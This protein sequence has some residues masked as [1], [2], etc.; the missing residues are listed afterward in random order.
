VISFIVPGTPRPKGSLTH[1]A[2]GVMLEGK[3]A[4]ARDRMAAYRW[5]VATVARTAM[6]RKKL[7]LM[8]GAL[9]LTVVFELPRPKTVR[10]ARP[11]RKPDLDKLTRAVCDSL[12]HICYHD[13][14][15]IVRQS[16]LKV[17]AA[18]EPCTIIQVEELP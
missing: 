11:W 2:P 12:T 9:H 13:D 4:D 18:G 16:V 7:P 10:D 15:Q 8:T 5:S 1:V 6:A 3:T 17:Y 14:A